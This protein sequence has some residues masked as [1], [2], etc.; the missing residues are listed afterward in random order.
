M[1][2]RAVEEAL[3]VGVARVSRLE[4]RALPWAHVARD[5]VHGG[6]TSHGRGQPGVRHGPRVGVH[7]RPV[8]GQH[9]GVM[10]LHGA[11]V[12]LFL[13]LPLSP[14]ILEPNLDTDREDTV[15]LLYSRH[16]VVYTTVYYNSSNNSICRSSRRNSRRVSS[17][18][19]VN[20]TVQ[21]DLYWSG[22]C[23]YRFNLCI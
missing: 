3:A 12:H 10:E 22:Q 11:R 2:W 18:E 14:T 5:S 21:N 23:I 9:G 15:L 1:Y 17:L 13:T 19:L 8:E 7:G 4:V 20:R 6:G 16:T